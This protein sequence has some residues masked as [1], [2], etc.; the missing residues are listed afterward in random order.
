MEVQVYLYFPGVTPGRFSCPCMG[1]VLRDSGTKSVSVNECKRRVPGRTSG[2]R[3]PGLN[4]GKRH[5]DAGGQ[6]E[7]AWQWRPEGCQAE[8]IGQERISPS[9]AGHAVFCSV[10]SQAHKSTM[11]TGWFISGCLTAVTVPLS[12]SPRE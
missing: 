5:G 8:M 1:T 10:N 12:L 7:F 11:Q 9:V 6:Q 3:S 2:N 4:A